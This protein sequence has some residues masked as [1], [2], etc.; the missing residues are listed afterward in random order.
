M[1]R[2]FPS[3]VLC[4]PDA[5]A[6][7]PRGSSAL[8][9]PQEGSAEPLLSLSITAQSSY[10]SERP[11]G[12]CHA[13]APSLCGEHTFKLH[14]LNLFIAGSRIHIPQAEAE[15]LCAIHCTAASPAESEVGNKNSFQLPISANLNY[16]GGFVGQKVAPEGTALCMKLQEGQAA[17]ELTEV[18]GEMWLNW[19][20]SSSLCPA[21]FQLQPVLVQKGEKGCGRNVPVTGAGV[22][23]AA[24]AEVPHPGSTGWATW[25]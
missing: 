11:R 24:Q 6:L 5:S 2:L 21:F 8:E 4:C 18:K 25:L 23:Q 16:N 10:S 20:H 15:L 9:C 13:S 19:G 3:L 22:L 1:W 7:A 12:A 17:D 14:Y